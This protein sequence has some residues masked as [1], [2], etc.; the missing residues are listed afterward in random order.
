MTIGDMVGMR[1]IVDVPKKKG[2][3]T[4]SKADS[5]VDPDQIR[6]NIQ[7]DV[8]SPS[9]LSPSE[10]F[11]DTERDPAAVNQLN[12]EIASPRQ[13]AL[14]ARMQEKKAVNEIELSAD[15]NAVTASVPKTPTTDAAYKRTTEPSS[16]PKDEYPDRQ[17]PVLPTFPLSIL[18][19]WL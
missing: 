7:G 13:N 18:F 12:R 16:P 19:M 17:T 5:I 4:P 10:G 2:A 6:F 9:I 8:R 14:S 11:M 3:A 1:G 15:D